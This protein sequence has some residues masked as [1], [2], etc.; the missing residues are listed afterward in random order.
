MNI[1]LYS[2]MDNIHQYSCNNHF[3]EI[4]RHTK[5]KQKTKKNESSII[6]HDLSSDFNKSNTTGINSGKAETALLSLPEHLSS[7]SVLVGFVLLNP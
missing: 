1:G 5:K 2:E 7:P 4:N 6:F 3:I